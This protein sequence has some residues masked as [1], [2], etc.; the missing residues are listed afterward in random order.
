MT[1]T[2]QYL[3]GIAPIELENKF[4]FEAL[5][6]KK[7]AGQRLH[8]ALNEDEYTDKEIAVRLFWVRKA[9]KHTQDLLEERDNDCS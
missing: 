3:Y 7:E 9:L 1:H 4:Y 6:Y 5:A 8:K 2:T